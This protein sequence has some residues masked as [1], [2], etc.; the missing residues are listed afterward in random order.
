MMHLKKIQS[1]LAKVSEISKRISRSP[2]KGFYFFVCVF[3][4][5]AAVLLCV[6]DRIE[7]DFDSNL[8]KT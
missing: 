4:R 7:N 1:L 3:R 8:S 2:M 5:F 6:C